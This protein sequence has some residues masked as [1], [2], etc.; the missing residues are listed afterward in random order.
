MTKPTRKGSI[1][2]LPVLGMALA[3]TIPVYAD[4]VFSQARTRPRTGH[5]PI[6]NFDADAVGTATTFTDVSGG[7]SATFSSASDPG[8]FVVFPTFFLTLTGNVLLDPGPAE[9]SNIPLTI[10]F[11]SHVTGIALDFAT[12]GSSLLTMSAFENGAPVGSVNAMGIIPEGY[13]YPEGTISFNGALFNSVVLSAPS[14]PYF[15]VDNI[16]VSTVPEP[17]SLLLLGTGL[18]AL[19]GPMAKSVRRARNRT[20]PKS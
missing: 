12:D 1:M 4:P 10:A 9:V 3:M 17:G 18:L 5:D 14:V 8:G 16:N 6:F 19:G 2:I 20:R 11:G 13:F 7:L 15:A